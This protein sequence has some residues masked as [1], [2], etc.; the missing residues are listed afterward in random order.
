MVYSFFTLWVVWIFHISVDKSPAQ[1]KKNIPTAGV[2]FFPIRRNVFHAELG[3]KRITQSAPPTTMSTVVML[4]PEG[5]S[6]LMFFLNKNVP[7]DTKTKNAR[8]SRRPV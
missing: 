2:V 6:R 8:V 5:A 3:W 4:S 7:I 1:K